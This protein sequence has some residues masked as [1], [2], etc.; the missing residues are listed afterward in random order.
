MAIAETG[1]SVIDC[2][3]IAVHS[4]R[5]AVRLSSFFRTGHMFFHSRD[6]Y[7]SNLQALSTTTQKANNQMND[8]SHREESK[9]TGQGHHGADIRWCH[10]FPRFASREEEMWV[11]QTGVLR[12]PLL[13]TEL[14]LD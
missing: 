8:K 14:C 1:L 11:Y 5:S 12:L 13:E 4:V 6:Y 7:E 9:Y 2:L 3:F 10:S